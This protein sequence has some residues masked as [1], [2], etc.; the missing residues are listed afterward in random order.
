MNKDKPRPRRSAKSV[1]NPSSS[2]KHFFTNKMMNNIAQYTNKNMQPAINKFSDPL[3]GSTKYI[4]LNLLIILK[5]WYFVSK[6]SL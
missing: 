2:F 1:K 4:H 5:L 3:D 6:S